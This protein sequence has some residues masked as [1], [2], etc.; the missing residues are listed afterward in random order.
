MGKIVCFLQN[1]RPAI[2]SKYWTLKKEIILNLKIFVPFSFLQLRNIRWG[3][4]LNNSKTIFTKLIFQ[5]RLNDQLN[6][7]LLQEF[8]INS[9]SVIYFCI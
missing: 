3:H 8:Y 4:I 1:Y 6:D 2:T 5:L 9:T 7:V